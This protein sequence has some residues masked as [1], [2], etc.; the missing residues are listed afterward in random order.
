MQVAQT[1]KE[2]KKVITEGDEHAQL[3]QVSISSE[4]I[5]SPPPGTNLGTRLEGSKNLPPGT[6]IVY[7]IPPLGTKQGVK[8]PTP[9]T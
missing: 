2:E 6:T 8:S 9:G 7:K 4:T 5:P 1:D 3:M